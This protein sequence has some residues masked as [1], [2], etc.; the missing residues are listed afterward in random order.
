MTY[1][2]RKIVAAV[3]RSDT[4][5]VVA[6]LEEAGFARDRIEI[7]G[8]TIPGLRELSGESGFHGLLTRLQLRVGDDLD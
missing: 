4:D 5:G 3:A 2:L 1:P 8:E 6:A 7:I